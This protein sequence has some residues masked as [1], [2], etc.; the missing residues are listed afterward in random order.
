MKHSRHKGAKPM[1]G[2]P[3][4]GGATGVGKLVHLAMPLKGGKKS[5]K[6]RS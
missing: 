3:R 2:T 1:V 5:V 6:C 4:P